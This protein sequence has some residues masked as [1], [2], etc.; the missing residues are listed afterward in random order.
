M[1]ADVVGNEND[2][3]CAWDF[4]KTP[5]DYNNIPDKT[6]KHSAKLMGAYKWKAL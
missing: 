4:T 2:L 6:G 1:N 5:V 3:I